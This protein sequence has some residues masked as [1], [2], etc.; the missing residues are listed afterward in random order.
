[1]AKH[2]KTHTWLLAGTITLLA[3]ALRLWT[4]RQSLPYVNHPDEPNPINYVVQMLRTGDLNP[5]A[6]QKPSLYVY[7]LLAV[8]ATR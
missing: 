5:H 8:V 3:L 4:I 2:K 1:M 7:L 6:F